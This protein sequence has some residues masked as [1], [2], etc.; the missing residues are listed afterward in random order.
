MAAAW[1]KFEHVTPDKPEIV[2]MA[3]ILK[4]DQD[5]VT[6][7]CL[8]FWI[9]ADQQTLSGDAISV[10][11][12]FLD[13]LTCCAGFA[14][15]LEEVGW[16]KVKKDGISLP[17][18]ARHN[19]ETA[20]NRALSADRMRKQRDGSGV[21]KASPEEELEKEIE[22]NKKKRKSVLGLVDP[23]NLMPAKPDPEN[24]EA[25]REILE[26]A[27][28]QTPASRKR[29]PKTRIVDDWEPSPETLEWCAK[30]R[31]P[32]PDYQRLP[33]I[34]YWQGRDEARP[35]WQ[36]TFRNWMTSPY[37]KDRPNGQ[38]PGHESAAQRNGRRFNEELGKIAAGIGAA[39][40][41]E[42]L[43]LLPQADAGA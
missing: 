12:A 33:F 27:A 9:W 1:I 25:T 23:G 8:R 32:D 11:K 42:V 22:K 4:I 38:Q 5:A 10:T 41:D 3:D 29:K 16:I 35:D 36:A 18:F 24:L 13:R 2:K 20:K 21:T 17:H 40:S 28:K 14:S 34:T 30:H 15:A 43:P 7:K 31:L 39:G 26:K 6:G 19:G 37:R